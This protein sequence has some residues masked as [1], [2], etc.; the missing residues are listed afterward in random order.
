[1]TNIPNPTAQTYQEPHPLLKFRHDPSSPH[2]YAMAIW[3]VPTQGLYRVV[4]LDKNLFE[5]SLLTIFGWTSLIQLN[6]TDEVTDLRGA[7]DVWLDIQSSATVLKE[8]VE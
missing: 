8:G 4:E 5:V 7:L 3:D 2:D 1:M 6:Q